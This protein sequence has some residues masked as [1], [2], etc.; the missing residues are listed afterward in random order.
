L[1]GPL[2]AEFQKRII[3]T[4]GIAGTTKHREAAAKF[5]KALTSANAM[6]AIKSSGLEPIEKER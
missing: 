6:P 4:A 1:A 3:L 5:I 2:P